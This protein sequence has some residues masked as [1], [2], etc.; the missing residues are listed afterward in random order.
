MVR[1]GAHAET[2]EGREEESCVIS[3]RTE[4]RAG[5]MQPVME[6]LTQFAYSGMKRIKMTSNQ[7][8]FMLL[9]L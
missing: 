8:N 3:G 9:S 7:P 4:E 6:L 1:A 5:A 2:G